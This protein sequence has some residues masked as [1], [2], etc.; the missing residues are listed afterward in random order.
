MSRQAILL[1]AVV[2]VLVLAL[3]WMFL[4]SPQRDELAEVNASI[5]AARLEQQSLTSQINS[6]REIRAR[7]PEVEARLAAT[8]ALI[9]SDPALPALVK[10]LQRAADEAGLIM[11]SVSPGTPDPVSLEGLPAGAAEMSL[12]LE[13]TGSYFQIVDFLRRIEDPRITPRA[14]LWDAV[15]VAEDDYPQLSLSLS[16]RM[17]F[18][19][20]ASLV[21]AGGGGDDDAD[22]DAEEEEAA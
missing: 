7:A 16:G 14:I 10:N 15:A 11:Q 4:L 20:R 18:I 22:D 17:F 6:L 5:E 1:T 2:T 3:Y 19:D 9:P 13:M 21:G 12:S 8:E